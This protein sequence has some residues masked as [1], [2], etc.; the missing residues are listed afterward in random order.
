VNARISSPQLVQKAIR[1]LGILILIVILVYLLTR[2]N[3][4]ISVA[5][6][7]DYL[8]L[9][10]SSVDTYE[11]NYK[12]ITSIAETQDLDLGTYISGIETNNNK[13]GIWENNEFGKYKL[14]IIANVERYMVINT[15]NDKYVF[16]LESV[17]ATD[18]FY[19]AFME[20]LQTMPVEAVP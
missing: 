14:C 17:D 16:N 15:S 10:Y 19:K 11:I 9:S 13:F 8:S 1:I 3:E 12:D 20:L 6:K 18:S 7:D 4:G 5:V 2:K